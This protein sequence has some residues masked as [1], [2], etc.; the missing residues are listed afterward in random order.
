MNIE[1]KKIR[2]EEH[3]FGFRKLLARYFTMPD[4][5]E[6]RFDLTNTGAIV[7]VLAFTTDGHIIIAKQFRPGPEK[8]MMEMPGGFVDESE[9][10]EQAAARELLEETGYVADRIELLAH[11]YPDGYS[12]THKYRFVAFDCKKTAETAHELDEFIEVE[13][14][15]MDEFRRAADAGESTDAETFYRYLLQHL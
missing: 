7:N 14:L 2:E 5:R 11:T 13:L 9:T 6:A 10:P 8:V 4:G 3:Q 1:W 12:T 15:T